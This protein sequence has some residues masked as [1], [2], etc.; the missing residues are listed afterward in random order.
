MAIQPLSE[1]VINRIAA[2]EVIVRPANALKEMLENAIDAGARHIEIVVK[3]GGLKMMKISDDGSGIARDDLPL[4]CQRFATSKLATFDDLQTI[5]T[6]GFRGEALASI[7]HVA[8]VSVVTRTADAPVASKAYYVDGRLATATFK[9]SDAPPSALVKP[10]S[11][12]QGTQI[13]VEDMFYN[14]PSRLKS[15]R[16]KSEELARIV[17][18]A[19]RYAIHCGD[20]VGIRVLSKESMIPV[21]STRAGESLKDRV[22]TIIGGG[23]DTLEF[24]VAG[25]TTGLRR[26]RGSISSP[27]Y[28]N[29]KKM[30][31]VIFINH[32]LVACEPLRRAVAAVYANVL[33]RGSYPFYYLSLDIDPEIL[34]V[35]MHPTKREVRFLHEDEIVDAVV[36]VVQAQL[37]RVDTARSYA[38][39]QQPLSK[40]SVPEAA[41]VA[42][43]KYRQDSKLVRVDAAQT[44]ITKYL[45]KRPASAPSRVAEAAE[46]AG[47]TELDLASVDE[48]RQEVVDGVSRALT[49]AFSN[50]VYIGVVDPWKRLACFQYDVKLFLFDY[51]A[52]LT[53]LF[54]QIC[55][56]DVAN[57]GTYELSP[58]VPLAAILEPMA[59]E[60]VPLADVIANITAM[61]PMF[62]EY[63]NLGLDNGAVTSLPMLLEQVAPSPAKLPRFFYR[64]G[65]VDYSDEKTCLRQIMRQVALMYL[66]APSHEVD[67]EL[68]ALM[69]NVLFPALRSRLL[70]PKSLSG[71]IIEVAD[72]PGLYRVF[73][74]C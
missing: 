47:R 46:P 33:P 13:V 74:R 21:V 62:A 68:N 20:S 34:D 32:R 40:R 64:L 71:D 72:L 57:L 17:E 31:T 55:L 26:V 43:K 10:T 52:V 44:K 60:D 41:A 15:M 73:E 37:A 6:Y 4:L 18:V 45:D 29:K 7:S 69:E 19:G 63:F 67:P 66:P 27:S 50:S 22:R 38:G 42:V 16:S 30:A 12:N 2:G 54:Y 48:L 28:V 51:A 14:V 35:N 56:E 25:D 53:Q 1:Q 5:G 23:A 11:G 59:G 70:A 9:P 39:Q 8:R 58:P 36:A 3:D 24:D 65:L 49:T 61:A